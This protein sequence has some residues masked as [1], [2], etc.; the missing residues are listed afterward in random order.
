MRLAYPAYR[1]ADP[2][3][4]S[5]STSVRASSSAPE[6]GSNGYCSTYDAFTLTRLHFIQTAQA[7]GLTLAEIGSIIG[8]RDD[9]NVPCAHVATMIDNRLDDVRARIRHLAALEALIERSHRL[10]PV[11]CTDADICHTLSAPQQAPRAFRSALVPCH[12]RL[13]LFPMSLRIPVVETRP[14]DAPETFIA[15]VLLVNVEEPPSG[16]MGPPGSGRSRRR[17]GVVPPAYRSYVST[18]IAFRVARLSRVGLC[19]VV[20]L[21][22]GL[23]CMFLAVVATTPMA[24]M[25]GMADASTTAATTTAPVA[26]VGALTSS[27]TGSVVSEVVPEAASP[28]ASVTAPTMSPMCDSPC[29]TGTSQTCRVASGLTVTTLLALLVASRRDTFVGLLPRTRPRALPRRRRF[30]TPWTVLSPIFLCVLRV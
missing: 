21:A 17:S 9:G 24:G 4:P 1:P 5:G 15:L 6:R 14:G 22:L 10:D 25:A 28:V 8:L 20:A 11:D 16:P 18:P 30:Q 2:A 23:T 12:R 19:V 26:A 7:E 13:T 3:R 29:V 27:L